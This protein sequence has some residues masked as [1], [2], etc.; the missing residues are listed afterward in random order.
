MVSPVHERHQQSLDCPLTGSQIISESQFLQGKRND[1]FLAIEDNLL[2]LGL[3]R[4]GLGNWEKIQSHLL[5]TRT[6]KQI[7]TRYKNL[8]AR[9]TPKNPIK[10][11]AYEA[12]KPLSKIEEEL[13]LQGVR[14]YGDDWNSISSRFLPHRPATVLQRLWLKHQ[15][16]RNTIA[17]TYFP[18]EDEGDSDYDE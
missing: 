9:R 17:D 4:Y 13:L 6:A 18:T 15:S 10:D 2:L 7:A 1:S 3:H 12:M 14:N 16:S 5:P 8:T 11:F